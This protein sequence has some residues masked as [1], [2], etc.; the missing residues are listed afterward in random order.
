MPATAYLEYVWNVEGS[1][2]FR[3]VNDEFHSLYPSLSIGNQSLL[4]HHYCS[5]GDISV[6]KQG[7]LSTIYTQISN[8]WAN[9]GSLAS[10]WTATTT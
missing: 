3:L 2:A 9:T 10:P 8:T 5:D 7:L 4:H 1:N 6:S